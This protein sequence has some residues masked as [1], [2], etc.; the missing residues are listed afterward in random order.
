MFVLYVK[1]GKLRH[2]EF[3]L[4]LHAWRGDEQV[5]DVGTGLLLVGRRS[6]W[7]WDDHLVARLGGEPRGCIWSNVDMGGNSAAA[8]Q[9]N[10]DLEGVGPVQAGEWGSAGGA[11]C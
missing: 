10:I 4:G 11:V 7:L 3:L 9:K 5:L 6:C 2:R 8:T 1:F